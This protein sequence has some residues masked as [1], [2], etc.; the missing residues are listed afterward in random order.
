M[1]DFLS[2]NKQLCFAIYETAG[3]FNKLYA[4]LLKPFGLTYPQYLVLLSLWEHDGLSAK[5]L[6]EKLHLGTGTLTPMLA[7]MERNGW[8]IKSRSLADERKVVI[9]L[10]EKAIDQK[11]AITEAIAEQI[12]ACDIEWDEYEN[13]MQSLQM[14]N[15]K[16]IVKN[17]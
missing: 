4:A 1:N 12:T 13:L 6:G 3:T 14:L 17:D 7:R 2:L 10:Q 9:R 5:E 16:I 8:I 15:K 11:A